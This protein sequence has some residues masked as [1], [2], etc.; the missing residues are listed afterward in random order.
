MIVDQASTGNFYLSR[1]HDT[2]VHLDHI[3][4]Q[5]GGDAQA[6]SFIW[7]TTA[8]FYKL[9]DYDD[10]VEST[11]AVVNY[12]WETDVHA[13]SDNAN[14]TP[15]RRG[16]WGDLAFDLENTTG[17]VQ[18][19][20]LTPDRSSLKV[21]SKARLKYTELDGTEEYGDTYSFSIAANERDTVLVSAK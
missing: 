15:R 8:N 21:P 3:T 17:S 19:G 1:F 2:T 12:N 14:V 16:N 5:L 20:T 4:F 7:Q 9:N 13:T 18:A 11:G 10:H 6:N